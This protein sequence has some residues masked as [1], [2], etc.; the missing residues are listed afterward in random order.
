[1]ESRGSIEKRKH[2]RFKVKERVFVEVSVKPIKV[3]E[4]IDISAGGLS[5][6]YLANGDI[7]PKILQIKIEYLPNGFSSELMTV[8][9]VW[10]DIVIPKY[11]TETIKTRRRGVCF[12]RLNES[13]KY[14]IDHLIEKYAVATL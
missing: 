2:K 3:G 9:T 4:M 13:Q 8:R 10:D 1:M 6:Q 5:F 14:Q 12:E 11:W 7:D